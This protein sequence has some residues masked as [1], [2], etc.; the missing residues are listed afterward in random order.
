MKVFTEEE[1]K[2]VNIFLGLSIK[3]A[4]LKKGISQLDLA[5]GIGSTNASIGRI[6]RAEHFSKWNSVV[7]VMQFLSLSFD[8]L[9]IVKD[10]KS[11]LKLVDECYRLDNKLTG[12]KE[13]YYVELRQRINDLF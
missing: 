11:I 6:E 1:F 4:R 5:V 7:E 2:K 3:Y 13:N 10:K 9:L 8:E 12:K